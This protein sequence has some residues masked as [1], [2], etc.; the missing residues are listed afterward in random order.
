M[1]TLSSQLEGKGL[2]IA[3]AGREV[4][5]ESIFNEIGGAAQSISDEI[6]LFIKLFLRIRF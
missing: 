1:K 4:L 3:P 2:T 6:R 5:D